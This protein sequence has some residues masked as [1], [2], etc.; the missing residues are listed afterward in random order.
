M[1]ENDFDKL[2]GG[3]GELVELR[4]KQI[5]NGALD[6]IRR[7]YADEPNK[8][9]VIAAIFGKKLGER[10]TVYRYG[11]KFDCAFRING[12]DSYSTYENPY[13]ELDAFVLYD[14]LTGEAVIVDD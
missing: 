9:E 4:K 7:H 14:L 8:M 5:L 13:I 2:S 11:Q 10:F 6:I 3:N 12:I 1:A